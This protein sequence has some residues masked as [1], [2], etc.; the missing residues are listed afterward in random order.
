[1][2]YVV[3][4]STGAARAAVRWRNRPTCGGEWTLAGNWQEIDAHTFTTAV[5][6]RNDAFHVLVLPIHKRRR[7]LG[8]DGDAR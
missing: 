6:D 1:V 8:L 2:S 3:L 7:Q 5:M 4:D